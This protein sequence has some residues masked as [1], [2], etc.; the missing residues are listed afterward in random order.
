MR[1]L[2]LGVFIPIANNG[3]IISKNAPQYKPT[4]ELHKNIG[5]LAEE[6][7]F[8]SLFSMVKWKG[9]GGETQHWNYSLESFTLMSALA[10][11]TKRIGLIA[12]VQPLVFNPV[13]TAKIAATID[14]ISNGRLGINLVTG[15]YFDEYRQMGILPENYGPLRYEYAQ[16]WLDI[17]KRLWTEERVTHEGNY[18]SLID[19]ECNPKPIQKPYPQIVCAG[20]SDTGLKFTVKNGN[21]SFISGSDFEDMKSYSLKAK[22]IAK[23]MNRPIKTNT[24]VVLIQADTDQEADDM[25]QYYRDGVDVEAWMNVKNI[26]T[27]DAAGASSQMV[28]KQAQQ[29][30]FFGFLP[31]AGSPQ[32]IAAILEDL[33]K[34][35]DLDGILFTFPD[36]LKG[37]RDFN[38]KVR[39]L[40]L[41]RGVVL[42]DNEVVV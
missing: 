10:A 29:D 38:D 39:P 41:E 16:E 20:M 3:W 22:Q 27:K 19:C 8:D 1:K 24:V 17:V 21:S 34:N 35:G 2:E 32:T 5:L 28:L 25:I 9:F 23:L 18:Y 40:L 11:V 31:I 36:Y 14:E 15:Q 6:L 4:W 30:V 37:L 7:H 13:A 42:T 26:Y 33:H 12:S